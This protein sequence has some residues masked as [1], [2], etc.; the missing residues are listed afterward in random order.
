MRLC[1][2]RRASRPNHG[3]VLSGRAHLGCVVVFCQCATEV[4]TRGLGALFGS[5]AFQATSDTRKM[6]TNTLD[7]KDLYELFS[8]IET[9]LALYAGREK[10]R[11][12][13][14]LL[15]VKSGTDENTLKGAIL[16][17]CHG[18]C[19][20]LPHYPQQQQ[21]SWHLPTLPTGSC[22]QQH[23]SSFLQAPVIHLFQYIPQTSLGNHVNSAMLLNLMKISPYLDLTA[24]MEAIKEHIL[25]IPQRQ[26]NRSDQILQ[27]S[28][29]SNWISA[30]ASTRLLI[31]GDFPVYRAS[32]IQHTTALSLL[33]ALL[34]QSIRTKNNQ[35]SDIKYI[36]LA[37]FCG[38]HVVPAAA[39]ADDD[40]SNTTGNSHGLVGG[41]AMMRSFIAQFLLQ[42][43]FGPVFWDAARTG[44]D[45]AGVERGNVRQLCRLFTWLVRLQL[46]ANV[47]QQTLVCMVDGVGHYETDDLEP[48]ML[49][50]LGT[51]VGIVRRQRNGA[52]NLRGNMNLRVLVTNAT[53]TDG[54]GREAVW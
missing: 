15:S 5:G 24:D 12:R 45:L 8:D 1:A 26:Q 16:P 9:S 39:A 11:G 48:D 47:E 29:F 30:N 19:H 44:I 20:Q 22:F 41:V 3:A 10:V 27:T 18:Y 6:V 14:W 38:R 32:E 37:F 31:E 43:P 2:E 42:R 52:P 46:L 53:P 49:E 21:A 23:P 35:N 50:V 13:H 28:Q 33:C 25:Q 36:P 51:L 7:A 17:N 34:M 4:N 40:D 54:V